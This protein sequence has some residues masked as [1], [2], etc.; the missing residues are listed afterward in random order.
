[1][2]Q[3]VDWSCIAITAYLNKIKYETETC[4]DLLGCS[5]TPDLMTASSIGLDSLKLAAMKKM[6]SRVSVKKMISRP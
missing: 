4:V 1:M 2:M 5:D 3:R 6:V